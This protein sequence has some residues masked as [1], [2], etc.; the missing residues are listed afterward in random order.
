MQERDQQGVRSKTV[1]DRRAGH[2][3]PGNW[4]THPQQPD[5]G[6]G[7]VRSVAGP[8]VTITFGYAGEVLINIAHVAL[9]P[10]LR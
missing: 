5:W 6:T 8:R 9:E 2:L 1:A 3:R 7:Q 4:V 10:L